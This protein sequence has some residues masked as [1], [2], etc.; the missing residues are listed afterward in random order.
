MSNA[1]P[2][3]TAQAVS[4]AKTFLKLS[5]SDE[6]PAA[7]PGFWMEQIETYCLARRKD[8]E[9]MNACMGR[10]Q[11]EADE[12]IAALQLAKR[13]SEDALST[14]EALRRNAGQTPLAKCFANETERYARACEILKQ[15]RGGR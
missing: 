8:S 6:P 1:I 9:S 3:R 14:A 7:P 15:H 4:L 10:L 2:Q 13:R 11:V 12:D 5:R